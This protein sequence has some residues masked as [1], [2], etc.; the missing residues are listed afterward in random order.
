MGALFNTP[1][2]PPVPAPPPPPLVSDKVVQ[3]A[4][5]DTTRRRAMADGRASTLLTDPGTQR[6]ASESQQKS[7]GTR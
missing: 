2:L 6:T 7:L 1:S 5:E 4:A 3:R